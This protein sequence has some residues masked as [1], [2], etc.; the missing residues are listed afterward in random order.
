MSHF[1]FLPV[2]CQCRR[3]DRLVSVKAIGGR[4]NSA[5][6][7]ERIE[8]YYHETLAFSRHSVDLELNEVVMKP[9]RFT[10]A[11][12]HAGLKTDTMRVCKWYQKTTP[13]GDVSHFSSF[14]HTSDTFFQTN[15][16][17]KESLLKMKKKGSR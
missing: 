16:R 17:Q 3:Q 9:E 2:F 11:P 15:L 10:E 1:P 6:Q 13:K 7:A 8:N 14:S 5:E 4:K 12:D